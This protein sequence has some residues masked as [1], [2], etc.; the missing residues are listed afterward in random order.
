[1]S[2]TLHLYELSSVLPYV[3]VSTEF[4]HV[5]NTKPAVYCGGKA[6]LEWLTSGDN[7]SDTS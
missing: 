5:R 1:M 4:E 7:Q 3:W 2:R 6:L